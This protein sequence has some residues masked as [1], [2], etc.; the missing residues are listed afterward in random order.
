MFIFSIKNV[1][2]ELTILNGS[3]LHVTVKPLPDFQPKISNFHLF[4]CL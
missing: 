3:F 1:K 4:A 2:H